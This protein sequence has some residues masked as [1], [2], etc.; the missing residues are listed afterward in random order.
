VVGPAAK[1]GELDRPLQCGDWHRVQRYLGRHA[2]TA[3]DGHRAEIR[4]GR[5]S[6]SRLRQSS[7]SDRGEKIRRS[8]APPR[9]ENH[10]EIWHCLLGKGVP[11]GAEI[12]MLASLFWDENADKIS[13]KGTLQCFYTMAVK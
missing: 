4:R 12:V 10:P 7:G 11:G 13:C 3:G 5:Q 8:P 6:G 1:P 2:G 9:D